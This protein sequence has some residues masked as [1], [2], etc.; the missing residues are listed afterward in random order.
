MIFFGTGSAN[1]A[2]I[3]TRNITCQ[4]CK[5]EDTIYI[6]IYRKHFH[7]FW[8]PV[9]PFIKSGNSFCSHCKQVLKPKEMPDQLQLQYKNIK[10]NVKGPTWQFSGLLLLICL[11]GLIIYTTGR[12]KLNTKLYLSEPEIG[13]IYKYR[14]DNGNYSTMKLVSITQDSLFLSLNDY[15]ISKRSRIYKIDKPENYPDTYFG[16]SKHEISLMEKDGTILE[17]NRD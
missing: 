2:S 4:H 7:I 14:V 16:Y 17:I 12:D 1:I 15:E 6:N 8:I 5:N 9:F 3:K 10:G 13:D 11:I